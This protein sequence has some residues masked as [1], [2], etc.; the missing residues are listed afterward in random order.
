MSRGFC[1]LAALF[2]FFAAV[3]VRILPEPTAWGLVCLAIG[4]A[5]SGVPWI[6]WRRAP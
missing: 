4:C 5:V 2:F 6:P 1:A 3:G